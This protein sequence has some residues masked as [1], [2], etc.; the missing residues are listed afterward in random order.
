MRISRQQLRESG[1]TIVEV[2]IA[3][4][5]VSSVLA[6]AFTVSQKSTLAVRDSQERAE[7]TQLL[8]GQIELVR[9]LALQV[10]DVTVSP[11]SPVDKY[12]CLAQDPVTSK[13]VRQESPT[14]TDTTLADASKYN[15]KCKNLGPGGYYKVAGK[16]DTATNAFIFNAVWDAINGGID[17]TVLRYRVLPGV[18][19]AAS[20]STDTFVATTPTADPAIAAAFLTAAQDDDTKADDTGTSTATPY[21]PCYERYSWTDDR[22]W[23]VTMHNTSDNP[24]GSLAY[25]TWQWD[26][27]LPAEWY[28]GIASECQRYVTG[29]TIGLIRHQYDPINSD[30]NKVKF[31]IT[32]TNYSLNGAVKTYAST[33]NRPN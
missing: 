15:A 30:P 6:G 12:F 8:Q 13:I 1:D 22:C 3:I 17:T 20:D 4:A 11:F 9:A 25:C 10:S 18:V 26:A 5:V 29:T 21:V 32:L 2:L 14:L 27:G 7:S 19:A 16:Y 28:D 31:Q 23:K 33:I 24:A